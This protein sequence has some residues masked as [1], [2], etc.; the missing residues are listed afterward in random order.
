MRQIKRVN[1]SIAE[2]IAPASSN[3]DELNGENSPVETELNNCTY[4]NSE[5]WMVL[6]TTGD[7]PTPRFNHAATVIGNKMVVVGGE[8][9][10]GLL[11][12]VQF[13]LKMNIILIYIINFT[14]MNNQELINKGNRMMD[15]TDEAIECSKQVVEET[16]KV[17]AD[18]S[19]LA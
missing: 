2:E 13:R 8:T 14:A 18:T 6:S 9:G 1:K 3:I 16:M 19:L 5:S 7:K 11:D 12:D 17:G 4:G 15:E 10:H